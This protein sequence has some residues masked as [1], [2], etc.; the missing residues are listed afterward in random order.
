MYCGLMG[1]PEHLI[2]LLN[3]YNEGK[4][5]AGTEFRGERVVQNRKRTETKTNVS[6]QAVNMILKWWDYRL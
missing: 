5:I 1:M 3:T 2:I 6:I 4:S